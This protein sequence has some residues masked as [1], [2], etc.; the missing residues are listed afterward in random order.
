MSIFQLSPGVS[1]TEYDV[2]A[3]IPAVATSTGAIAGV[4]QW[5]PVGELVRID[6]EN[7]LGA[8][9][10]YPS[11]LNPET[12][13]T[14]ASFLSYANDLIV[15]RAAN[16][17][18]T[19][20]AI[21]AWNAYANTGAITNA[22]S[23]TTKNHADYLNRI[24]TYDTN[25]PYI[26][27]YPGTAGNSLQISI[28]DSANAYSSN[29]TMTSAV[30]NGTLAI[31]AGSNVGTITIT[32]AGS[33]V[34]SDAFAMATGVSANLAVGD[35]IAVGN[36][37]IGQQYVQI[38]A[39]SAVSNVGNNSVI[40]LNF[41]DPYRLATNWGNGVINRYWQFRN[42]IGT[43]PGTT[44]YQGTFAN[45]AIKDEIHAV[46]VDAGGYFTG[47]PGTPLEVFSGMSRATD[48]TNLDG[49]GN[50]YRDVINTSKYVWWLNDIAGAVSNVS[51]SLVNSTSSAV[52]S[53][54]F[55][56]GNDGAAEG[57]ASMQDVV[58]AY[59]MFADPET[60]D[61]SLVMAGKSV[62]GVVGE[63]IGNWIIDNITERRKDCVAFIS[64]PQSAVV[65]NWGNEVNSLIAFRAVTRSSSYG[66]L[67]SGYKQMYDMYNNVYRWIPLNGDMAGLCA[68]VDDTNDPWWAPAGYNRGQLKN[69]VRLAFNPN[70]SARN[71]LFPN[72]INP[73]VSFPGDGVVLYG[74]KTMQ[75]KASA[76]DAINV[77]RL[78][79]V[80]EKAIAK[81]VK[82]LLW[83][84][85]DSYTQAQF[86]NMVTPY[87][88]TV[89]GRRGISSF[90]VVCD[91]TNNTPDIINRDMMVGDIYIKPA[92]AIRN[93]QLNFVATPEGVTFNEVALTQTNLSSNL[94]S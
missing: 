52:H 32:P 40:T 90:L 54:R 16:T 21:G 7:T 36:S 49:T 25:A 73:V 71:A 3:I 77:R 67:D 60:V 86:R 69:V 1:I 51:T 38:S 56:G 28:C 5:G 70:K 27:K 13:F 8:R 33:G 81:A 42:V 85:N 17:T 44:W 19:N 43:A 45:A 64:P 14:A 68:R 50:Y 35:Q 34:L 92:R 10:G 83:E 53:F 61:I 80:L 87:L 18:S 89:Q 79:I 15:V 55:S 72:N 31:N 62:G 57:S 58:N 29:V 24:G 12:W 63:Q 94:R 48:A 20:A 93:I 82:Y 75:A 4:F 39:I 78:F 59:T 88:R 11:N 76:L 23:L 41:V 65:N 2:S 9:M 46:I 84:F 37:S 47:T 91:S 30:A 22:V 74:D 66:F 6:S 26:A